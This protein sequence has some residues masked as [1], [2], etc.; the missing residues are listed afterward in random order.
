M[1]QAC[2]CTGVGA[3]GSTADGPEP[4]GEPINFTPGAPL[5]APLTRSELES[6]G[7]GAVDAW[8]DGQRVEARVVDVLVAA[9]REAPRWLPPSGEW[10]TRS[11]GAGS[12]G[13]RPQVGFGVLVVPDPPADA[14]DTLAV[15]GRA[16]PVRTLEAAPPDPGW[17]EPATAP[18]D[19]EALLDLLEPAGRHP[20]RRWRLRLLADRLERGGDADVASALRRGRFASRDL[21]ALA[22]HTEALWRAGLARLAEESPDAAG[23]LATRLTLIVDFG[24]GVAAPAW[25]LEQESLRQLRDDL[26]NPAITEA[27]C[28]AR[29]RAWL[30]A[31]PG[32]VAW[33]QDDAGAAD[34]ANEVSVPLVGFVPLG[35]GRT[36]ARVRTVGGRV[37]A[38]RYPD[39]GEAVALVIAAP[40]SSGGRSLTVATGSGSHEVRALAGPIEARPPGVPL[41][42]GLSDWTLRSWLAGVPQTAPARR[43][44]A[45]LL[46]RRAD[47][48]GWEIYIEC[49]TPE[50]DPTSDEARRR[51]TREEIRL[52]FGPTDSP[53]AVLRVDGA[54]RVENLLAPEEPARLAPMTRSADRWSVYA[55]VPEEAIEGAGYVRIALMRVDADGVRSTWPRPLAPWEETPGRALIDLRTWRGD[56][57]AR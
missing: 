55:P 46:Q 4:Q 52:W 7:L 18:A 39:Q 20:L 33:V 54:G 57:A 28:A 41:G 31:E 36:T 47:G 12:V 44:M 24:E 30:D 49:R 11:A 38:A 10:T 19:G 51:Q 8:L 2:G 21:E 34:V 6:L 22:R 32:G 23:R 13:S 42:P 56:I 48:E 53:R 50:R 43:A 15:R 37:G 9:G 17:L 45:G 27:Q 3:A 26:L 14:R 25:P 29:A 1:W 5:I 16:W 35:P 40:F